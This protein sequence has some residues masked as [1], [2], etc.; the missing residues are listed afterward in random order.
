MRATLLDWLPA[1]L[2]GRRILDAGCGT[3]ALAIEAARR[4]AHVVAVHQ[5]PEEFGTLVACG[6]I[7]PVM[8]DDNVVVFLHPVGGSN[9]AGFIE[10][11]QDGSDARGFLWE[12]ESF[13]PAWRPEQVC[14]GTQPG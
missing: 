9:Q 10:M 3:G 2:T 7:M 12:L 5:S 14:S 13:N 6:Q 11:G 1:D 4:G 8:D